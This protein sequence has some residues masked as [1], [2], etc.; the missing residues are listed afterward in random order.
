MQRG[1]IEP[2]GLTEGELASRDLNDEP[3]GGGGLESPAGE[4]V[5]EE[6]AHGADPA[7]SPPRRPGR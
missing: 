2:A 1:L 5:G 4:E 3:A 6:I 7:L